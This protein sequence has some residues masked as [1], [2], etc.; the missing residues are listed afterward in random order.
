MVKWIKTGTPP[1]SAP[2]I[3]FT[4]ATPPVIARDEDGNA[5]GGIRLAQHAVP[6]A[7]NTGQNRGTAFCILYGSHVDFDKARLATLYP[8]HKA[9][10]DKVK[11]VTEKNL[12]AGY[13]L[14]P[15]AAVAAAE[16]SE[17]G[18]K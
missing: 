15:D 14:K 17:I 18:K 1:P 16:K 13:I 5:L 2:G 12:K 9:Y 7:V 4:S 8:S 10:V 11:E 6:T 3:E